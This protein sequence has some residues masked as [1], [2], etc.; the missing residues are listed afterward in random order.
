MYLLRQDAGLTY[1]AIAQLLGKKDHSTVVHACTQLH[2]E[3]G[4]ITSAA[5]RHRRDPGVITQHQH[6]RLIPYHQNHR[7]YHP[8]PG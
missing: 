3:L 5:R 4:D 6:S 7:P 8:L 1:A 2:K